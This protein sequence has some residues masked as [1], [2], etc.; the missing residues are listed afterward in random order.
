MLPIQER[1]VKIDG[2]DDYYV[3]ESGNVYSY[4]DSKVGWQ[5]F[6]KL[7]LR[8][9]NNPKRYLQ[10]CL[11]NNGKLKY[12][13]VHR[14]VA[15]YFCDG[16]FEGAVV[17]HKNCDIHDNHYTNLEWV[18]Q[19]ENIHKSYISSGQDETRNFREYALI[20]PDNQVVGV[21]KGRNKACRFVEENELDVSVSSLI[22]HGRSRGYQL[23]EKT[24]LS[25]A[26]T[27]I[28]SIA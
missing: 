1:Y 15:M 26:Q 22:R 20:S 9:R 14:L 7:K 28:E 23:I 6:R 4:R 17:N 5:G 10:V 16:Y 18:T 19:K 25:E 3:T 11:C 21:F 27:T 13:Q 12:I 24:L 8:G 2:F